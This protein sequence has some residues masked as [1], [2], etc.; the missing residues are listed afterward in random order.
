MKKQSKNE[1]D[2]VGLLT[3][4]GEQITALDRKVETLATL[5]N[6]TQA[7]SPALRPVSSAVPSALPTGG[8]AGA[9]QPQQQPRSRPMFQAVCAD[10]KKD[11]ELPFKPSGD[12]P[13]YCKECF[14]RRKSTN[15]LKAPGE[16]KPKAV[17]P[18]PSVIHAAVDLPE[19][20]AKTVKKPAVVKKP[21]AKKKPVAAKKKK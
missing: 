18:S 16:Q 3:K 2:L 13:V 10:C 12:R 1:T 17:P 19:P 6:R 5:V 20:S 9:P 21:A 15:T 8:R 4:L 7:Q 14:S 11:C